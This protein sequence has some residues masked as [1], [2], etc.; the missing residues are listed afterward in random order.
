MCA[1]IITEDEREEDISCDSQ[2]MKAI[3]NRL[4]LVMRQKFWCVKS[5]TK[6]MMSWTTLEGS[7]QVRQK[8]NM[9]KY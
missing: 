9:K 7:G 2:Y 6:S 4:G 3:M 1:K 5:E 8:K